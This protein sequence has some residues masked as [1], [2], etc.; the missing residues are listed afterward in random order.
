[1][2]YLVKFKSGNVAL[3]QQ[4]KIYKAQAKVVRFII[5]RDREQR[6][7]LDNGTLLR[8]DLFGSDWILCKS[9]SMDD[10]KIAATLEAL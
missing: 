7:K 6:K 2:Y 5:V 1:M 9:E 10:I 8:V 3:L 4:S